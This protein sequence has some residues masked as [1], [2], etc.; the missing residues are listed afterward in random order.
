M[1][2][3]QS[4]PHGEVGNHQRALWAA[5]RCVYFSA[6]HELFTGQPATDDTLAQIEMTDITD[7]I[8]DLLHLARLI[9][10]DPDL[11]LARG[12]LYFDE[13]EEDAKRY[14][15]QWMAEI[16]SARIRRLIAEGDADPDELDE[17]QAELTRWQDAQNLPPEAYDDLAVSAP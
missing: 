8:G 9:G 6:G 11:L 1:M 12:R 2:T 10:E 4:G 5:T 16:T 17:L 7:L 13:E 15:P 14:D 3:C